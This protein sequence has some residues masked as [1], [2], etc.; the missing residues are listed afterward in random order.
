MITPKE[1]PA[2]FWKPRPYLCKIWI[3]TES[4]KLDTI[5]SAKFPRAPLTPV[6]GSKPVVV[7]NFLQARKQREGTQ[8]IINDIF[9][10]LYSR[11]GFHPL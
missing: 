8:E 4:K 2:I 3:V 1:M 7:G 10:H 6:G 9:I 11:K 5:F